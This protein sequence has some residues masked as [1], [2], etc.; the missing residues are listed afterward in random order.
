MK[1]VSSLQDFLSSIFERGVAIARPR[2]ERSFLDLCESLL[3]ERGE[4]SGHLIASAILTR[5]EALDAAGRRDFFKMLNE[6]FDIDPGAI[7]G[8]AQEYA[9]DRS[10]HNYARLLGIAEPRRQEL[11]RRLNR[12][13]GATARLVKMREELLPLLAAEP[14]LERTDRDFQH[15]FASWFNRGF[16]ELRPIDWDAPA[17]LL[18]KIIDYEAVHAIN[19]WDDLRRRMQPADR[20]CFAF[21]HPAMPSDP[22][23]FVEVALTGEIP[24]S[25]QDVLAE[26]RE[27]IAESEA[28]TAVFYSISNCQSGLRGVSFGNFLIKQVASDL[29]E[30]LP[31]LR[32]FVTLSP[33]PGLMRWIAG[34]PA[35]EDDSE[36]GDALRIAAAY[37]AGAPPPGENE[38]GMAAEDVMQM[39]AAAYLLEAKR[40]D[41]QP[42]DPVARFHLGNGASL[43]AIHFGADTSAKGLRESASVMVNYRYDLKKVE[44]NHESYAHQRRVTASRAVRSLLPKPSRNVLRRGETNNG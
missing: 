39:L 2:E 43:E 28:N 14:Q 38:G 21:F 30:S 41:G 1:P 25:I 17:R 37:A 18:E 27:P 9:Q 35:I 31:Q 15:L 8:I 6:S 5:Y 12:V 22:L 40:D 34:H 7:A 4:V 36:L 44:E 20:R 10:V 42:V 19:D 13:S 11:L 26:S 24:G 23:I 29:A 16:L 32:N 33:V 3:S